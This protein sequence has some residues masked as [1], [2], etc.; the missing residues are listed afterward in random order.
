LRD[1]RIRNSSRKLPDV[2]CVFSESSRL[3]GTI[4]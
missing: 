4:V 3:H 2:N 1:R